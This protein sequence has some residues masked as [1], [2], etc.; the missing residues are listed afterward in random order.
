MCG[1]YTLAGT[2][3]A[4]IEAFDVPTLTFDFAPSYNV[5]PG[6][7]AV[8]VATDLKGR[9]AGQLRWGLVPGWMDD[10]GGGFIN[11]RAESVATKPSFREAF[12]RRRC[13]VPA[14]GFYEWK[15]QAGAKIPHWFHPADEALLAF[16]GIWES[17]VRPG[18][19]PRHTFAILT[20]DA[21]EDVRDVHERMPVVVAS[22]DHAA[23]LDSDTSQ[24]RLR[25]MLVPSPEGT[26]A[27]HVVSTR[28]NSAA[29]DDAE[30]VEPSV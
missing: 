25:T 23:W 29:A 30:L 15:R 21:N 4:L 26:F 6:Q 3:A 28:V 18:A 2:E 8:V 11:A 24:E 5:A 27:V 16:A 17:W 12:E 20:T 7:S 1:R 13:L 10:P 9:R 19:E 14:D 22:A